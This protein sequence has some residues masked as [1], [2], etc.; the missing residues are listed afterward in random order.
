MKVGGYTQDAVGEQGSSIQCI[1]FERGPLRL[2]RSTPETRARKERV[3]NC[4][5]C[6]P[7]TCKLGHIRRFRVAVA[8]EVVWNS[9]QERSQWQRLHLM[10][11]LLPSSAGSRAPGGWMPYDDAC[12]LHRTARQRG[13]NAPSESLVLAH[14]VT[15]S[16]SPPA[17]GRIHDSRGMTAL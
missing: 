10:C 7:A 15:S 1:M 6:N 16:S 2:P 13:F 17:L 14:N 5:S 12:Q 3:T 11:S 4:W 8:A 9:A